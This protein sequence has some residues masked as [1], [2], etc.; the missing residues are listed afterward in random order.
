MA[1]LRMHTDHTLALLEGL[2]TKLGS[3]MRLFV[4]E[5]CHEVETKELAREY[6]ARKRRETRR[7]QVILMKKGGEQVKLRHAAETVDQNDPSKQSS[8]PTP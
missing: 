8:M 4:D 1:K 3:H 5:T 7:K 2:T 6:Q